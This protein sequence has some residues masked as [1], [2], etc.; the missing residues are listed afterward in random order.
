MTRTARSNSVKAM[1]KDR[2]ISRTGLDAGLRKHGAGTHNWGSLAQ[3]RALEDAALYDVDDYEEE[4]VE[5]NAAALSPASEPSEYSSD[6]PVSPIV[7]AAVTP[8]DKARARK[9]RKDGA[10]LDLGAIAR[11]SAAVTKA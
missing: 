6:E 11:S 1:Q 7:S 9:I 8:E 5:G 4:E 10:K 2:S 3:E